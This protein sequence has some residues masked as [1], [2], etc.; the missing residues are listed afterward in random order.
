MEASFW[1][2]PAAHLLTEL[3]TGSAGLTSASA[4]S[5]LIQNGPNEIVAAPRRRLLM[6]MLRRLSNPLILLLLG[7]AIIAGGTGDV[8]SFLIILGMVVLSTALGMIQERRAQAVAEALRRSIALTATVVRDGAARKLPVWEIVAG[9]I[10]NLA[11]GDLVPADGVLLTV[12]HVQVNEAALTGEAFPVEK[13]I[14][15]SLTDSL[16]EARNALFQGSSILSGTAT[17][18][19]VATGQRTRFGQI[20]TS[21]STSEPLTAFERGMHRLGMLIVKL[22][23]FLVLFVLLAHLALGRPAIE[24]F[25]FALALA[26]GLTPELLPMI[27]TVALARGAERLARQ[28]VIVKRL[29]AIHDLGQMDILCT[30]KTGTLTEA[31]MALVA[32]PGPDGKDDEHVAE[33][34]A[35]NARFESGLK[36]P[37][38]EALLLHASLLPLGEWTKID[39]RPFDFERRRVSVLAERSGIRLEIVKGAPEA[40]VP[41]CTSIRS[42]DGAIG[43]LDSS[44]RGQLAEIEHDYA[45]RGMRLLALA[46]KDAAGRDRIE[47]D[48]DAGLTFIGYCVFLDPPKLSAASAIRDMAGRGVAVRVISGDAAPVVLHLVEALGLSE[49]TI[50]T[51]EEIARLDD[52]ALR[53]RVE[54]VHLFARVSPDQKTRIVRALQSRGHTVGFLGDGINDAPAIRAADIGLSVDGATDVAREAADMILLAPDLA[55]LGA[56]VIEGRRTYANILK[57]LRMGTSSNFG[58]ML[59]MAAASLV[60]PFLPLTAVQILLNN[61]I[62]DLSQVGIP[63]DHADDADLA[64]PRGWDMRALFRFTAIMGPLS[65]LFDAATFLVLIRLGKA[66]AATFRA[67][68]FIESIATQILVVFVI[69]S[70]QRFW[71]ARPHPA[72]LTSAL[73]GLCA[74]ILLPFGPWAGILGFVA[75]SWPVVGA[76]ALLI[77]AYL[78]AAEAL[79]GLAVGRSP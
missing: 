6:D 54:D 59:T 26:V 39:E 78:G 75:P 13:Q 20:S 10:V 15:P 22:T 44:A 35:V 72:L 57:Y 68:W 23:I 53:I 70:R 52:Q 66:D 49:R 18:L 12:N 47:T 33:L 29:S 73:F 61:L 14:D 60:L 69:R 17:M 40:L 7:A 38:D 5:R 55:V 50:M 9:D 30:D 65:S 36:S 67:G 24:S 46:T 42:R 31:R 63:F 16:A 32:H 43:P 27:M 74:A 3:D 1:R 64:E 19:V 71:K 37:L 2:Q 62:Y 76:I 4:A 51:G 11:A 79:K 77:L 41:L 21:L 25:L 56:G 28:Q 34:A 45:Q 8:S 48:D 58:N